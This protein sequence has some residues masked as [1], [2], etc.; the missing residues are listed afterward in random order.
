MSYFCLKGDNMD[1]QL[2]KFCVGTGLSEDHKQR[3]TDRALS[4]Y[5]GTLV[6]LAELYNNLYP[7]FK[8]P[9]TAI[10]VA[11]GPPTVLWDALGTLYRF[12]ADAS[13]LE[14]LMKRHTGQADFLRQILAVVSHLCEK[15][16]PVYFVWTTD[17][18]L[19]PVTAAAPS[20]GLQR[21]S[22]E[23]QKSLARAIHEAVSV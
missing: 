19:T 15:K 6:T 22:L 4:D 12:D 17:G 2:H 21:L 13:K 3:F 1:T 18:V 8:F 11:V 23:D 5:A 7:A 10:L 16:F 9:P 20:N 14:D